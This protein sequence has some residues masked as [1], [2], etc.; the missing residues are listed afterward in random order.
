VKCEVWCDHLFFFYN[1]DWSEFSENLRVS[2]ESIILPDSIGSG[3][4]DVIVSI[5]QADG[6]AKSVIFNAISLAL[7]D[8]GKHNLT[9]SIIRWKRQKYFLLSFFKGIPMK[10]FTV[11]CTVGSLHNEMVLGMNPMQLSFRIALLLDFLYLPT[12]LFY[13]TYF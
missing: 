13:E 4:I 8:A 12:Y 9:F 11:S 2:F 5:I 7:M 6:S 3:E 10:D 1:R